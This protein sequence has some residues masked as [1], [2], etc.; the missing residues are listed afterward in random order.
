MLH[1]TFYSSGQVRL[2]YNIVDEKKNGLCKAYYSDGQNRLECFFEDDKK[3]GQYVSYYDNGFVEFKCKFENDKETGIA[4][5]FYPSG[6]KWIECSYI[7]GKKEGDYKE[8]LDYRPFLY[9]DEHYKDDLKHGWC[10]EYRH[11][12]ALV[13]NKK[14]KFG[15]VV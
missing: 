15:P 8:W 5:W 14:Y 3:H 6:N 10:K 12:G 9:K 13:S 4:R 7:N 1:Q 11:D 2:E